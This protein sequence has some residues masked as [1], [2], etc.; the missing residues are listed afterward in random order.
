MFTNF[1]FAQAILTQT[2][3]QPNTV[4]IGKYQVTLRLPDEGL[5]AQEETDVEFRVVDTTQK[6]PVEEGFKGVGAIDASATITMPAMPG[7]P[8]AKPSVH[9]EGVPGDYGVVVFFP[10]GGQYQLDLNLNVPGNGTKKASFKVD[11]KDERPA[12]QHKTAPFK[13]NV[14]DWPKNAA[15]G[16]AISLKL[17]VLDT[18]ANKPVT[19]FDTAHE[20][21]L[22]LLIASKDLN[23][24]RHE[25]PV[26]SAGGTWQQNMTF[27]AGGDYWVYADVA[28]T[29]QG[30]RVLITKVSVKG[31][32]P[33][34]D[35]KLK[36]QSAFRDGDLQGVLDS[37]KPIEIGK[38]ATMRVR[39][40]N[41]KSH[42]STG[43]TDTYLGALGHLMIFSQDGQT[44]VHS[45]PLEDKA[46]IARAKTGVVLFNARFPKT[47][48]Y[49]AYAQ[50]N[51]QGKVHTLGFGIR[52]KQL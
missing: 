26:M 30:S 40:S 1:I 12:H 35:T 48:L 43:V 45:H 37:V 38:S 16:R 49:K 42:K 4:A 27:P 41:A 2:H 50:F 19:N 22:H 39:L 34:W 14:L 33:T 3:H 47:G 52:V 44:V 11:V 25:H 23:W 6:D 13:L 20:R 31:S 5:F 21:K 51:W 18:K 28:P 46:S 10:H 29:G 7:M 24:F 15:A 36:V 9:R 32:K 8:T 17:Q